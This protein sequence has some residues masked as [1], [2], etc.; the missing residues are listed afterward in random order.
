MEPYH[1]ANGLT[2]FCGDAR[3]VLRGLPERSVHCCVTSPPYW[4]LRTYL[5]DDDPNKAL[6]LGL[7]PTP[8]LYV[9]H[10]VEVFRGVWRVLRD[11]GTVF[12][13]LGDSYASS[14]VPG[15]VSDRCGLQHGHGANPKM[16]GQDYGRAP[17]PPGL[18]PKDLCGIPWRVAFALQADGW[19]LRSH[20]PWIKTAGMPESAQDRPGSAVETWLLLAKSPRYYWDMEAV[21]RPGRAQNHHDATGT[22]YAAPGQSPQRGNRKPK[23]SETFRREGSKR[24]EVFPGQRYGTHRPNRE[25]TVPNPAGRQMRNCDLFIDSLDAMI[26]QTHAY[27]TYLHRIRNEGGLLLSEDEEPL[28]ILRNPKGFKDAHFATFCEELIVPLIAASSSEKGVCPT[29]GAPWVRVVERESNWQERKTRGA[30]AGNVGVSPTYQNNVHGE[31]MSHD[32]G[33]AVQTTGWRPTCDCGGDPAPAV[34]LDPFF[35]SGTVGLVANRLGRR[36]IGIDLKPE[37]CDMAVVRNRQPSLLLA[38]SE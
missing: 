34:V 11:D 30:W 25:D 10:L 8:D 27:L 2:I 21:R 35:G 26:E 22:G 36:C 14:G 7:E 12:L 16:I 37:Y 28:A 31:G 23:A 38:A 9:E 17:T 1:D 19:Y 13:N 5:A 6:E 4:G 15:P 3:D 18:K 20:I 24:A 33:G 32:L 29:C